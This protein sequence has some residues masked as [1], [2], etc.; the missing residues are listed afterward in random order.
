[1]LR[2]MSETYPNKTAHTIVV[3]SIV[4]KQDTRVVNKRQQS[5][6]IFFHDAFIT[7]EVYCVKRWAKITNE[8]SEENFFERNETT[9]DT[10]DAGADTEESV[11]IDSTIVRSGNRSY[12][13]AMVRAQRLMVEYDN[14]HAPENIPDGTMNKSSH[15]NSKWG[16]NGQCHRKLM[17]AHNL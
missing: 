3:N 13:I 9:S 12:D 4:I 10:E 6:F 17:G 5:V 15:P 14:E 16:W 2:L 1:M 7:A 8:G 11:P